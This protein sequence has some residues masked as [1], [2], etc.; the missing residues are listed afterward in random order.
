[1]EIP[2]YLVEYLVGWYHVIPTHW[3]RLLYFLFFIYFF[4]YFWS[5]LS[6]ETIVRASDPGAILKEK[7]KT[8]DLDSLANGI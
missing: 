8:E 5:N 2:K 4:F 3:N 7:K 1:M 6:L